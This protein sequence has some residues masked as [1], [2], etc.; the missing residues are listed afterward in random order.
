MFWTVWAALITDPL[1]VLATIVFASVSVAASF[2][3]ATGRRQARIA[4]A[5][6]RTLL[7]IVGV[8]VQV[9]GLDN[10]SP[11]G[12][13]VF[14]SNHASYMDTPVV[15]GNVPVQFRFLAKRGLFMIPFLGTH[16]QR[17]G[18]I[19]VFRGNARQNLKT[20]GMA[21]ETVQKRSISLLIFPE[22]G[23]SHDGALRPFSEGAAYIAI[24]A[25]V[26]LVPLTLLGT[27]AVLPFGSGFPRPGR[28]RMVIG[29][30]IPTEGLTLKC[31]E[32]ITAQA[33][34]EVAA[35]LG[36]VAVQPPM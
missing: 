16:L 6:S 32:Q 33:R 15:L 24:K 7:R 9:E 13:Y 20:L 29:K 23:R 18:H 22:G 5:W 17:A 25:G 28:A 27:R 30:P 14:A 19:P 8:R 3:D 34:A 26:P 35:A 1:I 11:D 12:V 10:I 31:R 36:G 2:F 4:V 21:A